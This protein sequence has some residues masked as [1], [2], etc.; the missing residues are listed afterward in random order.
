MIV[1]A[2]KARTRKSVWPLAALLLLFSPGIN[3]GAAGAACGDIYGRVYDRA[4]SSFLPGAS[5]RLLDTELATQADDSGRFALSCLP[6]GTYTL[7]VSY[8]GYDSLAVNDIS[9]R[10]D[11][12]TSVDLAL[13]LSPVPATDIIVSGRWD[14]RAERGGTGTTV[15]SGEMVRAK[16]GSLNDLSRALAGSIQVARFD[17]RYPS[18]VVRGGSPI[19]N[20][21]YVDN[22]PV[23]SISHFPSQGTAGGPLGLLNS[24][25][26]RSAVFYTGGF[27]VAYGDHLSSIME[28]S[29]R[30]G[31]R[32]QFVGRTVLDLT[33][34]S[35]SLEGPLFEGRS[36]WF[37]SGRRGFLSLLLDAMDVDVT[38][39][40]TDLQGK[41]A[42]DLD[43]TSQLTL[44]GLY[45][46]GDL[47]FS[48]GVSLDAA[49]DL[50]GRIDYTSHTFGITWDRRWP[51]AG[52]N[53]LSLS[54]STI[55]WLNDNYFVSTDD[56]MFV[57]D[58]RERSFTLRNAGRFSLIGSVD[59]LLGGEVEYLAADYDFVV[60]P[61]QDEGG[62]VK[63]T[64]RVDRT[65]YVT[66]LGLW[67]GFAWQPARFLS[68]DI[69]SR[70]D[71]FG[72]SRHV[73][74]S[75]RAALT[76]RFGERTSLHLG[77]G[78]YF[79]SLPAMILFPQE[80]NMDLRE[81]KAVQLMAG[82]S[83][84][85]AENITVSLEGFA[86]TYRSLP[87]DSTMPTVF[88]LDEL[89]YD[90]GFIPGHAPLV[91]NGR[92][93]VRGVEL[94]ITGSPFH[95]LFIGSNCSWSRARYR[96]YY[97]TWR[98][99]VVDNR[100]AFDLET[101]YRPNGA[102]L[103][104]ARW[105]FGGG[106]PYTPFNEY[107]SRQYNSGILQLDKAYEARFPDYHSLNIRAERTFRLGATSLLVYGEIWNLYNR[108]NVAGRYWDTDSRS[109]AEMHQFPRLPVVGLEYTF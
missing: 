53:R 46:E 26:V 65:D 105:I 9:V 90:Y 30:E 44:L 8:L 88:V 62:Y 12:S 77:A 21:F 1:L 4:D 47:L 15:I 86:K 18:L 27:P 29:L 80:E 60:H 3:G 67:T 102:W 34:A 99:R 97:G 37:V 61:F 104:T 25:L 78:L 101:R 82:F 68:L 49:V 108:E 31:N 79:Q 89:V 45:G 5:V 19:E 35:F 63:R 93:W 69:G 72:Y 24:H 38:P 55:A 40:Y 36:S 11:R 107:A 94:S 100:L 95:S 56:T 75:P 81:P 16:P 76:L 70:L 73:R 52:Y 109:P 66:S 84:R 71:R 33:G 42:Y 41:V 58:S 39:N 43:S 83:Y 17:D 103:F 59:I 32:E 48:E 85:P 28:I 96:D 106:R 87:M 22:I 92:A 57:N 51:G 91:D 14:P 50:Y 23:P 98:N 7:V 20:G 2:P 54:T 6:P 64:V 74:Y 10:A 13:T